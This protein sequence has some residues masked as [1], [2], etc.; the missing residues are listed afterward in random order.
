MTSFPTQTRFASVASLLKY[1]WYRSR[2]KIVE[3]LFAL[4]ASEATM[5]AVNAANES[6]LSPTGKRL[7]NTGQALSDFNISFVEPSTSLTVSIISSWKI[8]SLYS[9]Y[10]AI[11]GITTMIGISNF[12]NAAKRIPER[13]VFRSAPSAR[14]VM[15]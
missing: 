10:A 12:N 4:P 9:T 5:A 8:P 15:Y 7:S 6:P 2:V 14:C 1:F 13:A 3:I 11:P